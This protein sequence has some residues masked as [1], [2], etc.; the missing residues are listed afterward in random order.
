MPI[1]HSRLEERIRVVALIILGVVMTILGSVYVIDNAVTD[2]LRIIT[3][4]VA[5]AILLAASLFLLCAGRSNIVNR[6]VRGYLVG[7]YIEMNKEAIVYGSGAFT[8]I[9][10]IQAISV[11]FGFIVSFILLI[12]DGRSPPP[13]EVH[14]LIEWI[15]MFIS[16]AL[17]L[18]IIE[19][20]WE[21][22]TLKETKAFEGRGGD[23]SRQ[24]LL[25]KWR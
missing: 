22:K 15:F 17:L 23:V 18:V 19:L 20:R 11:L 13:R 21:T 16:A 2:V 6:F 9:T 25:F 10:A 3:A 7:N 1:V 12:Q 8:I 4:I 5:P 14:F 24:Q